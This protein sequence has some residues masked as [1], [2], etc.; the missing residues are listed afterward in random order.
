MACWPWRRSFKAMTSTATPP[1]MT[2]HLP[3]PSLGRRLLRL[4]PLK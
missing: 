1:H 4:F 2:S 3:W